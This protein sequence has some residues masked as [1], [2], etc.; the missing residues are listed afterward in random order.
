VRSIDI[1]PT[2]LHAFG[3]KSPQDFDGTS[4]LP[5]LLQESAAD[6]GTEMPSALQFSVSE[7]DDAADSHHV[8]SIRTNDSKLYMIKKHD[9]I[10]RRM[11]FDLEDDPTEQ[12]N[13][14]PKRQKRADF[15]WK[16]FETIKAQR[17]CPPLEP[18]TLDQETSRRLRE[19]GYTE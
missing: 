9:A 2:I 5:L 16:Q 7:R 4:L 1:L 19:L 8:M 3:I 10:V 13:V 15:L 12:E 17:E 18:I 11:F 6:S 14:F